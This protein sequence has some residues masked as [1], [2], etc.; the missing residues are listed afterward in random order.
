VNT[1]RSPFASG[2]IL[3]TAVTIAATL[4]FRAGDRTAQKHISETLMTLSF[5]D[6]INRE[7][8]HKY[9]LTDGDKELFT[10]KDATVYVVVRNGV[11]TLAVR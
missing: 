6:Q 4:T 5:V 11:K 9:E 7:L 8:G 3:G 2:L 10:V 1:P